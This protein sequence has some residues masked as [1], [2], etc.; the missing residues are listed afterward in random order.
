MPAVTLKQLSCLVAVEET[1]HFRRAAER[2]G[3]SQPALSAQ[4]Q[5]LEDALTVQ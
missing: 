5:N 1:L 4:I 2:C 3:M